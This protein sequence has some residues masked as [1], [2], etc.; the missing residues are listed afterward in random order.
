MMPATTNAAT[1]K[2]FFEFDIEMPFR[3]FARTMRGGGLVLTS[4]FDLCELD[5]NLSSAA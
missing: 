1:L 4:S 2:K 3:L 5:P